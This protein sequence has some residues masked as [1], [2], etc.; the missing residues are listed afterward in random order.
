MAK[1]E[2]STPSFARVNGTPYNAEG[3]HVRTYCYADG[4]GLAES[5][6]RVQVV[7]TQR[8]EQ[9]SITAAKM[10]ALN[11]PRAGVIA[12]G[13]AP[14]MTAFVHGIDGVWLKVGKS[15]A[16]RIMGPIPVNPR[17]AVQFLKMRFHHKARITPVPMTIVLATGDA[18]I[19]VEWEST[20]VLPEAPSASFVAAESSAMLHE[21]SRQEDLVVAGMAGKTLPALKKAAKKKANE[22]RK[23]LSVKRVA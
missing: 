8:S 7:Q 10:K 5:N 2:K 15:T 13:D 23:K 3:G 22:A 16:T 4:V 6:T 17:H 18:D 21:A 19:N 9:L 14:L 11:D 20:Y 12:F 1:K